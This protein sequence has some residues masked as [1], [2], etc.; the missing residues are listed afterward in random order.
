[1]K[2]LK[3]IDRRLVLAVAVLYATHAEAFTDNGFEWINPLEQLQ[4]DTAGNFFVGVFVVAFLAAGIT[5]VFDK[6][7]ELSGFAKK[8]LYVVLGMAMI[9]FVNKFLFMLGLQGSVI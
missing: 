8:A 4:E 1:M 9:V 2:F 3:L 7:K 5:L 6:K